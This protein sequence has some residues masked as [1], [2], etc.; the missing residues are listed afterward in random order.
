M[1]R[2]ILLT[3]DPSD[4]RRVASANQIA[5][6]IER[7]CRRRLPDCRVVTVLDGVD[8]RLDLCVGRRGGG[9]ADQLWVRDLDVEAM[10]DRRAVERLAKV[11]RV[12]IEPEERAAAEPVRRLAGL[13]QS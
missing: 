1:R 10:T 9:R 13:R 8:G 12:W 3:T 7:H 4:R 5:R 11:I 6:R 2:N